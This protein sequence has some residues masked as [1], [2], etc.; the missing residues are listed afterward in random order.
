[1]NEMMR[2]LDK[3]KMVFTDYTPVISSNRTRDN[4]DKILDYLNKGEYAGSLAMYFHDIHTNEPIPGEASIIINDKFSWYSSLTYYVEKY[5]A[6][7]TE[8]MYEDIGV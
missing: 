3:V 8:E 1:M 7:L 2:R 4:K 6:K 5:N